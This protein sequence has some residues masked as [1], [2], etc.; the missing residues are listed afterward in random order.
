M[1][2]Q[3][4]LDIYASGQTYLETGGPDLYRE[5]RVGFVSEGKGPRGNYLFT[6]GPPGNEWD[7][8]ELGNEL[9]VKLFTNELTYSNLK[10]PGDS[11]KSEP[12]QPVLRFLVLYPVT[13]QEEVL[14]MMGQPFIDHYV[15]LSVL[16]AD[17]DRYVP[18]GAVWVGRQPGAGDID[19]V[20]QIV[21]QV[22][23]ELDEDLDKTQRGFQA[24]PPIDAA[25]LALMEAFKDH[26]LSPYER[27]DLIQA[28]QKLPD[29]S[30]MEALSRLVTD[31]WTKNQWIATEASI[32]R[33]AY[34]L[35]EQMPTKDRKKIRTT[36]WKR[37]WMRPAP[38]EPKLILKHSKWD[39][40][41]ERLLS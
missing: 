13:E 28:L 9:T 33:R 41:V 15:V 17:D 5:R 36:P 1:E 3:E 27:R 23:A 31:M 11:Q 34:H 25:T 16:L 38:F 26:E 2:P 4:L 21:P 37:S 7:A 30:F 14:K 22:A 24:A 19:N 18:I 10:L 20:R 6:V 8:V 35:K 39:R 32:A 40:S 12:I 29:I